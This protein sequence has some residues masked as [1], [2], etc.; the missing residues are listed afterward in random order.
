MIVFV[1][2]L[3]LIYFFKLKEDV[4]LPA[5]KIKSKY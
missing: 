2:N 1:F 3:R 4:P 5:E